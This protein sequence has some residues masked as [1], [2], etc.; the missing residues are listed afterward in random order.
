MICD[1]DSDAK[2]SKA[3]FF[4]PLAFRSAVLLR[5]KL[6]AQYQEKMRVCIKIQILNL[7]HFPTFLFNLDELMERLVGSICVCLSL[8]CIIDPAS[9]WIS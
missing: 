5:K 8:L 1:K 2:N 9:C 6:F 4:S 3:F 7:V